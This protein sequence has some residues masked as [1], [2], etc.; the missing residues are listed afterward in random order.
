[1]PM[2]QK[3]CAV[4]I[5]S[6]VIVFFSSSCSKSSG[7]GSG[8]SGPTGGGGNP[9]TATVP[10]NVVDMRSESSTISLELNPYPGYPAVTSLVQTLSLG[11][12]YISLGADT[13]TFS[14]QADSSGG[15]NAGLFGQTS[16]NSTNTFTSGDSLQY[17]VTLVQYNGPFG[18]TGT[19][20]YTN[21]LTLGYAL[22]ATDTVNFSDSYGG[23][24]IYYSKLSSG[25]GYNLYN[26]EGYIAFRLKNATGSR[27]GWMLAS[28]D[29]ASNNLL[30]VYEIAYNKNYN[31]PLPMG[32]YQ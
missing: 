19:S 26:I 5:A 29:P 10:A 30:S 23:A 22:T 13:I 1:M 15:G 2:N 12:Y 28:S 7:S 14:I 32:K 11:Y 20:Y 17:L 21:D 4:L 8:G 16:D 27:Y 25:T 24:Q 6:F 9:D 31:Q 3:F 18:G